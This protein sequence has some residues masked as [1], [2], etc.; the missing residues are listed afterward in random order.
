VAP[1]IGR[2]PRTSR[3][4][5]AR[6]RRPHVPPLAETTEL[7]FNVEIDRPAATFSSDPKRPAADP[8]E[9]CCSNAFKFTAQGYGPMTVRQ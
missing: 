6:Q 5:A 1:V 9:T 7:A 4:V 2:A 3:S 8:Q